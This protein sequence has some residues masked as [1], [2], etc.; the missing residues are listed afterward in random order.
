MT[1]RLSDAPDGAGGQGAGRN[2]VFEQDDR[3]E[4]A[5]LQ[6]SVKEPMSLWAGGVD[7]LRPCPRLRIGATGPRHESVMRNADSALAGVGKIDQAQIAG[8][9]DGAVAE[10]LEIG[11]IYDLRDRLAWSRSPRRIRTPQ[12]NL[13]DRAVEASAA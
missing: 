1:S 3:I 7:L 10:I 2:T 8:D 11:R 5:K 13:A 6:R 9:R 4:R 12:N